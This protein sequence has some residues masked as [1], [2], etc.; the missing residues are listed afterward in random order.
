MHELGQSHTGVSSASRRSDGSLLSH[1]ALLAQPYGIWEDDETGSL[2]HTF[3]SSARR[4]W[5][6][7]A[8][9]KMRVSR[10]GLDVHFVMLAACLD[11]SRCGAKDHL[12]CVGM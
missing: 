10:G 5:A 12:D 8:G 1:A 7:Q 11:V 3:G 4:G 6:V 9:V 2:S